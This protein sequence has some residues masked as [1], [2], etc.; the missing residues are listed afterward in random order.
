MCVPRLSKSQL[1]LQCQTLW[2]PKRNLSTVWARGRHREHLKIWAVLST[3]RYPVSEIF[4][5]PGTQRYPRILNFDEYRPLMS[6][7]SLD[8]L[9][10][11][12]INQISYKKGLST[13]TTLC[14]EWKIAQDKCRMPIP[15]M[16]KKFW[17]VWSIDRRL[18]Y[19]KYERARSG[20][21]WSQSS[22]QNSFRE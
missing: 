12:F 20:F 8:P 3:Q 16:K 2:L 4:S 14:P 5:V 1:S 19:P 13:V 18:F 9:Y 6:I 22:A 21:I 10:P 17:K 15:G 11:Y 7:P